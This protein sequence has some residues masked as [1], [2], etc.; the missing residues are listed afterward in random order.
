MKVLL[1]SF[2]GLLVN[3][4]LPSMS[5][6]LKKPM[7][8][9]LPL[10]LFAVFAYIIFF[11]SGDLNLDLGKSFLVLLFPGLV[12]NISTMYLGFYF[13]RLMKVGYKDRYTI[14]IQVGL[15]NSALA[16]YI[17]DQILQSKDM[18]F[19]AVVYAS[20]SFFT[21]WLIA[22]RMKRRAYEDAVEERSQL[23]KRRRHV[24]SDA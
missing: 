22:W 4:Y 8:W 11:D 23:R 3:E 1:P 12:L 5:D 18:V 9:L 20:F 17:A 7:N 2:I 19:V 24:K 21:T 10:V 6:A 16:I 15:Q 14:A 13:P